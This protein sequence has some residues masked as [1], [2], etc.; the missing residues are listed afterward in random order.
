MT[1]EPN[2]VAGGLV[3]RPLPVYRRFSLVLGATIAAFGALFAAWLFLGTWRVQDFRPA[4]P[5]GVTGLAQPF[6]VRDVFHDEIARVT[7]LSATRQSSREAGGNV[8][9]VDLIKLSVRYEALK[10]VDMGF[11]FLQ[12]HLLSTGVGRYTT[13]SMSHADLHAGEQA[14]VTVT[15]F[16]VATGDRATITYQGTFDDA[17]LIT[18][19]VEP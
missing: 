2:V 14:T 7:V 1:A 12:W 4:R 5:V 3:E 13:G 6:T 16:G 11:E 10:E 19:T 18:L 8:D 9:N 15:L 17:P